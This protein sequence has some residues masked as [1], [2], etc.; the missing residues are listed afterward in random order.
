MRQRPCLATAELRTMITALDSYG[1]EPHLSGFANVAIDCRAGDVKKS[2]H[3]T[4]PAEAT[5]GKDKMKVARRSIRVDLTY[6]IA[7]RLI[8]ARQ[9]RQGANNAEAVD[10]QAYYDWRYRTLKAEF[11]ANFSTEAIIGKD[12]LDFG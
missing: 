4:I 3:G 7:R 2:S 1:H 12:I 9:A 8:A 10:W 5:P 11:N 6:Q